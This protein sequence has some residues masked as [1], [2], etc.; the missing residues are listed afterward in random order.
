MLQDQDDSAEEVL[1]QAQLWCRRSF[2]GGSNSRLVPTSTRGLHTVQDMGNKYGTG[3][4][5]RSPWIDTGT[6]VQI[7]SIVHPGSRKIGTC[8]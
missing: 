6:G 3:S 5:Y 7:C 2:V 1:R 4:R 8:L